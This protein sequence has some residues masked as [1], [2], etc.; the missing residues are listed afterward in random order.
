SVAEVSKTVAEV[1]NTVAISEGWSV[2]NGGGHSWN[3]VVGPWQPWQQLGQQRKW[4]L[5]RQRR[6]RQLGHG[7]QWTPW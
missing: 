3:R 6:R 7:E 4:R 2:S 1:S 5:E